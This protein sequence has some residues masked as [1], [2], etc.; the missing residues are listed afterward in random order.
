MIFNLIL[1][2]IRQKRLLT[3]LFKNYNP[4]E[5]PVENDNESLLVNVGLSLQQIVDIV[6]SKNIKLL[7]IWILSI[8]NV[9]N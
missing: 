8:N 3:S 9:Y 2:G 7:F 1:A 6:I 4:L 5:R